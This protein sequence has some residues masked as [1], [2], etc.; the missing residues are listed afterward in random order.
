[1]TIV[2]AAIALI[3]LLSYGLM[4]DPK[5]VPPA[6]IDK[7]A[8]PFKVPLVQGKEN[9]QLAD[10][11]EITLADL[12]GKP[13]VLNFWASW[14]VSCREEA[15]E[16]EAFWEGHRDQVLVVGIA[17]QDTQEAA[18]KFAA[19]FGKT[20]TLGLDADGKAAIDYG[21]SGVPETFLVDKNGVIRHKEIGPVTAK[22][23]EELMPQIL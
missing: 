4:L 23:L 5:R 22:K 1:M 12:K 11:T 10:G 3:G 8:L 2:G 16:L 18:K 21:V 17:I 15:K 6:N 14:C 7:A 19:Y 13:F 20:Y 9:L